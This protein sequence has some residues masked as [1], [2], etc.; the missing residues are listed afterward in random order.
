MNKA[1]L[2]IGG[3]AIVAAGGGMYWYFGIHAK[4]VQRQAAQDEIAK[5]ETRLDA[6]RTCIVGDKPASADLGE[7]LSVRELSPD[8]WDSK[9]CTKLFGALSRGPTEDTG[10]MNVEHAWMTI[11]RAATK[12][13]TAFAVHKDPFGMTESDLRKGVSDL[14]TALSE[15]EA[16]HAG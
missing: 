11:D 7:A 1:A 9:T 16:A 12:A 15:L 14:P 4:D 8:P 13:A 6:A 2:A 3:L 10:M 5:W